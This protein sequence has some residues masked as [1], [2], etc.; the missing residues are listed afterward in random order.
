MA[1]MPAGTDRSTAIDVLHLAPDD[2]L[3]L[4][5]SATLP[6][7]IDV[8]AEWC[9]PCQ[10]LRPVLRKFAIEFADRMIVAEIDGDNRGDFPHAVEAFPTLLLFRNGALVRTE[11]GFEGLEH[12]SKLID[13]FLE[14]PADRPCSSRETSFR[15]TH[16]DARATVA[17]ITDPSRNALTPCMAA[18]G[19]EWQACLDRIAR[20]KAEGRLTKSDA[21]RREEEEWTRLTAPFEDKLKDF[22]DM[23]ALGI[24]TYRELMDVAVEE[25]AGAQLSSERAGPSALVC[26]PGDASCSV[27]PVLA[28]GEPK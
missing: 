14:L 13:E 21:V 12:T 5:A 15:K 11:C 27:R 7:V 18:I 1:S 9:A 22:S 26:L 19:P 2:A 23:Q 3:Q 25:F 17:R 4:V 8:S 16:H 28:E 20:E 10:L 6:V 24:K